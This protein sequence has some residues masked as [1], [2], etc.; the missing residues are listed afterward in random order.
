MTLIVGIDLG[1]TNS[2]CA[3]FQEGRPRLVP[4]AHGRLMTPSIVGA[5][6]N[7]EL[8]VG[9]PAQQYRVTHPDR[10]AWCFKRWMGTGRRIALGGQEFNSTELSSMVLR[11][12]RED[13]EKFL[14][15]EVREAVITV[16]AYFN[17]NQRKA[18]VLAGEMA[19]LQVR[20]II[21]EPTAAALVYGY[22][23]REAEENLVVVDLGGGTFDVTVMQIFEGTLEIISTAG[24]TQLGGEDFTTRVVAWA[25]EQRGRR[26]ETAELQVP[27]H[28]ARLREE[29]ENAKRQLGSQES[30]GIRVPNDAGEITDSPDVILLSQTQLAEISDPLVKRLARPMS[31]ALRD[32]EVAVDDISEVVLVG[33]ATRSPVVQRFV[34]EF[35]GATPQA[36][37]NP[38]EVVALGAALQ[39]ALIEDDAAVDDMV[40]TDICPFTLGVSITREFGHREMNGYFLPIIH[41]NT[42]IPVSKEEVVY[43]RHPNQREVEVQVYQGESRKVKD[44]LL[45]GTL[46]VTGIPPGPSNQEV[47]LRFTY[48][49]NGILEVEAYLPS[50]GKKFQTV[51]TNH[52]G[53]LSKQEFDAAVARMQE[54]KF[55]PR[56]DVSNQHLIR[57]AERA[58]GEVGM[59]QR[60]ELESALDSFESALESGDRE[61]FAYAREGLLVVLSSLGFPFEEGPEGE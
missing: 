19:G 3:V 40:M 25:L 37:F 31:R 41:R 57:F 26:L 23:H 43:T 8:L 5:L 32:A 24:E 17:D 14:G 28:V 55:Y 2:L 48:D 15:C 45:L 13:A 20:R 21:N 46:R 12:L 61:F 18:T 27:L 7:G 60:S 34:E 52:A 47:Y 49:L 35:L 38:D 44:N 16:P 10:C 53:G 11:S 33:G 4:N 22:H 51:L 58:V 29:C 1:T 59:H 6:E 54:L 42:T 50:T 9:A 39:G 36:R 30:V 56:D